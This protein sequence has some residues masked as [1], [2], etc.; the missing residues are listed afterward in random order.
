[1]Q[2]TSTKRFKNTPKQSRACWQRHPR[3]LHTCPSTHPKEIG[4]QC[5]ACPRGLHQPRNMKNPVCVFWEC[6]FK[7]H[8]HLKEFSCFPV[9][10]TCPW[11]KDLPRVPAPQQSP[12]GDLW[13]P[14]DISSCCSSNC[15]SGASSTWLHLLRICLFPLN[16]FPKTALKT[17]LTGKPVWSGPDNK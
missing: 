8:K 15:V 16:H 9:F 10:S 13:T 4:W 11:C 14:E 3:N 5:P 1:M 7:K 17:M 12:S 2:N 6:S